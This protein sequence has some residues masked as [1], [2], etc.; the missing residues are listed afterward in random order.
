MVEN[1]IPLFM[2]IAGGLTFA[3]VMGKINQVLGPR[4]PNAE[5]YTTYESG[6]E[7]VRTARERFS[8]KYYLVAVLFI[9]FD[10]EIVFLYPWAVSFRQLG[11]QG[12]VVMFVF[13]F[14]LLVGFYY[15]WRKGALEWD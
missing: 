13:I 15:V 11:I 12:F 8:V 5:K 7:P 9:L 4:R 6:M 2:M 14:V 1:Y 10:I 3:V